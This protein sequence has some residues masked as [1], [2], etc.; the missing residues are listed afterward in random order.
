M[1]PLQRQVVKTDVFVISTRGLALRRGLLVG[2]PRQFGDEAGVMFPNE[3]EEIE[4]VG[5]RTRRGGTG[6]QRPQ[7]RI[8]MRRVFD[9]SEWSDLHV[10]E[11]RDYFKLQGGEEG[12]TKKEE[13]MDK[14]GRNEKEG[15]ARTKG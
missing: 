5:L 8:E 2:M 1:Q 6:A 11:K 12:R 14:E 15:R 13:S 3:W 9:V 10:A 7:L 4:D